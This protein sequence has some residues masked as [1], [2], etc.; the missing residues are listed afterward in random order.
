MSSIPIPRW[1]NATHL[2]ALLGPTNTGK[3]YQAIQRML[4]LGGGMIGLPLRLLAREVYERLSKEVPS[5]NVALITGEERIIPLQPKYWVCTVESMPLN[6]R[7]PIVVIDEIQLATHPT[8]GHVFTDRLLNARGVQETWFLGAETMRTIIE[9]LLPTTEFRSA[10]RHSKLTYLPPM[11]L[12]KLPSRTAVVAFSIS[13][14]YEL[15]ERI[16]NIKGGVA[17]VFGALSPKAR[18]AQVELFQSGQVEYLVA[19]DAIGMGLNLDIRHVAFWSISKFD[20]HE[21]R[22]LSA[23]EMAQ[24]AGRA[25]R[26]TKDGSFGLIQACADRERIYPSTIEAIERHEFSPVRKVWYR[27]GEMDFSSVESLWNALQSKPFSWCLMPTKNPEDENALRELL[28][29][30]DI[31][32]SAQSPQSLS[33]LWDVCRIPNFQQKGVHIHHKLMKSIFRQLIGF[34]VL[35]EGWVETNLFNLERNDGGISY[36]FRQ[37]EETRT[38]AYIAYKKDWVR[39]PKVLRQRCLQLEELLS[40]RLHE[41]LT[42]QFVDEL[43]GINTPKPTPRDVSVDDGMVQASG[44]TLGQLEG[45]RFVANPE[46]EI[47]FGA[48]EVRKIGRKKLRSKAQERAKSFLSETTPQLV[49]DNQMQLLWNQTPLAWIVA[50]PS[51][52]RPQLRLHTLD[53]LPSEFKRLIHLRLE[54]WVQADIVKMQAKLKCDSPRLRGILYGLQ[55]NLGVVP[56]DEFKGQLKNL[57][58]A[59][60][61]QLR[62]IG[63]IWTSKWIFCRPLLGLKHQGS[64]AAYISAFLK[65]EQRPELHG[66]FCAKAMV[67]PTE[68]GQFMG[69]TQMGP[70]SVRVD[71]AGRIHLLLSQNKGRPPWEIPLSPMSW[72][73]CN[74]VTWEMVI[75]SQGYRIKDG[76]LFPPKRRK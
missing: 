17:I 28:K 48:Q 23:A 20:G 40:N 69:Y 16:R 56:I 19:T 41:R 61:A 21:H 71:I 33:L 52:T 37:L 11:P 58:S 66:A 39:D 43:A 73:G 46:A 1:T 49:W 2:V 26:Y 42:V 64:R 25:G 6:I 70:M 13:H 8:R 36:V 47:T 55:M 35:D 45:F 34:G 59:E 15:A 75:R 65:L 63:I 50:G 57:K 4:S 22:A 5:V 62:K 51:I 74:F 76:H 30:E 53:L 44:W 68:F 24:I 9:S 32:R 60:R 31:A 10:I 38:W 27:H 12:S 67:W 7:T 29:E 18:N 3:T 72:L 14:L 54:E